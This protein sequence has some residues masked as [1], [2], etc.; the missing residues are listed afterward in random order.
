[1]PDGPDYGRPCYL[2][3][4]QLLPDEVVVPLYTSSEKGTPHTA[5]VACNHEKTALQN[6]RFRSGAALC[7]EPQVTRD[8]AASRK[9]EEDNARRWEIPAPRVEKVTIW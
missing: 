7:L 6:E 2:P 3:S 5:A 9:G 4:E 1:M 8:S